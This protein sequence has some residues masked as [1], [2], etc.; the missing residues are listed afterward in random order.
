MKGR[1]GI[2]TP[3]RN[4][5]RNRENGIKGKETIEEGERNECGGGMSAW[6]KGV[7][8]GKARPR[9]RRVQ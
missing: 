1:V 7:Q 8:R 4:G 3:L 9:P 2:G 6:R 5:P